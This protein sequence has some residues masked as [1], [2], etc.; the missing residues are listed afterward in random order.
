MLSTCHVK[1]E[2][3][4]IFREMSWASLYVVE[5]KTEG[6]EL[7]MNKIL[8]VALAL[9]FLSV[10]ILATAAVQ[11]AEPLAQAGKALLSNAEKVEVEEIEAENIL[12]FNGMMPVSGTFVGA[13]LLG[14]PGAGKE[15]VLGSAKGSLKTDGSLHIEVEGLVL[16]DSGM[17]PLQSFRGLAA[18][19]AAD[20]TM[21]SVSTGDFPADAD[22]NAEI[23]DMV[24]LPSPC[25]APVVFV[26]T[27]DG[28]WL[29]VTGAPTMMAP[30]GVPAEVKVK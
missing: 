23:K 4:P 5:K 14:V 11:V 1:S 29:A 3:Y 8:A 18:C 9:L 2:A 27:P 21:S 16:A 25:A 20:G 6:K 7:P 24:M 22:G 10:P 12:S 26:T 17:N 28:N 15:W 19:F 13:D 30:A